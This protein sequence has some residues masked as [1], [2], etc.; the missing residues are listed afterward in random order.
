M[1][2][3]F[4]LTDD[5]IVWRFVNI[6]LSPMRV[7]FGDEIIG[8]DRFYGTLGDASIA[9]DTSLGIDIQTIR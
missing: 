6:D 2:C 7:I 4:L 1:Q 9:I 3:R 5:R 8:E